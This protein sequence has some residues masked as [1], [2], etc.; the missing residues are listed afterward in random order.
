[1]TLSKKRIIA[2]AGLCAVL[3]LVPAAAFADDQ[4][5]S[6]A[7]TPE[8]GALA[9]L[10]TATPATFTEDELD[11]VVGTYSYG[12]ETHEI[13][14]RQAIEDSMS[15]E[16]DLLADGTYAAPSAD[17][18]VAYAR[19]RILDELVQEQ[20]ITVSDEELA[21][22]AQQTLGTNDIAAIAQYYGMEE[23]QARAILTEAAAVVKLRDQVVG[24]LPV[25]PQA[26]VAPV[27]G[28]TAAA[29]DS[30]GSYILDLAG[31]AWDAEAGAWADPAGLYAQALP[32]FDGTAA[33]FEQAQAAYYV[34]YTVYQQLAAQ[35]L[36]QWQ[37]YANEYLGNATIQ[38]N[39]LR[40]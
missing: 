34:A 8:A 30:Y 21:D 26:P 37:T 33:S 15:L 11:T 9:T 32:D 10:G 23:D 6:D 25:A 14:A 36:A 12:G 16:S 2:T 20:G 13:T 28:D 35:Q 1:M 7:P 38:I 29:L 24:Q 19:N 3:A 31:A 18:I 4:A 5:A 22:Y 17:L 39:T 40:S 27:D